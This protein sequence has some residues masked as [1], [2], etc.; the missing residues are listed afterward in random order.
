MRGIPR[1]WYQVSPSLNLFAGYTFLYLSSVARPADQLSRTFPANA[2][3]TSPQFNPRVSRGT[4][5]GP[6][7]TDLFIHGFNFGV[8]LLY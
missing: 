7:D 5:I 8:T 1:R 3:V 4:P 6:N 2:L